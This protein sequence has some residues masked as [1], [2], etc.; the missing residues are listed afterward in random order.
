[1]PI[2]YQDLHGR[3][4]ELGR[5]ARQQRHTLAER[6]AQAR[7]LLHAHA[8]DQEGLRQVVE[9]ALQLD[10]TL[11]CAV[12]LEEPLTTSHPLPK[13]PAVATLLAVDGSQIP[14]D[15]HAPLS[16]AVINIGAIWMHP[17]SGQA[18][19]TEAESQL[20]YGDDLLEEHTL[21]SE[22][23]LSL[24]RDLRERTK[25]AEL[26]ERLQKPLIALTDGPIELWGAKGEDA[27]AYAEF[28]REHLH[29]LAR[30]QEQEVILAGYVEKPFANLMIRLLELTMAPQPLRREDLLASPL[31]GVSDRWLFGE[32]GQPLLR[33][34][35]RSA[36]FG[37]Q[38]ASSKNYRGV[39]SLHFF[40]LNVGFD[41]HPWPV[42]V[43]VPRWVAED[44][45]KLDLLHR[46]LVEQCRMM[47][48]RPYP[49]LLHRAHETARVSAE[50][51]RQIE[52][53]L[54]LELRRHDGEIDD[55]SHKQ[56][57]KQL[58]GRSRNR[59]ER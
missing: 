18:P 23:A 55:L 38:S 13:G 46:A 37:L 14:P 27:R 50:E 29:V 44:S 5:Q 25:L 20:I 39:F 49:Y 8:T 2:N 9:T 30:L 57:A 48:S 19:S 1:M 16:F 43:E 22:S 42:R 35:E 15:R 17:Q 26:A 28:V 56:S 6:R 24:K 32:P 47:G 41:Q 7:A 58:A 31:R 59:S 12:P 4:R 53:W 11:R 51:K 45:R 3:I 40:Y 21:I 34:G 36:V 10:P 54:A 52:A 33:A